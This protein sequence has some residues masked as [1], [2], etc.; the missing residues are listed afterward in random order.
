[1]SARRFVVGLC[2]VV[3]MWMVMSA[4]AFASAPETPGPV[5]VGSIT[6]HSAIL[7][8]VLNPN[9]AG[10]AGTYEFLYK[11]SASECQ[12]TSI[13]RGLSFGLIGEEVSQE[14]QG[15]SPNTEYAVC[16]LARSLDGETSLSPVATFKTAL[17]PETPVTEKATAVTAGS[18]VLHGTLNPSNPGEAGSYSFL[19]ASSTSTCQGGDAS[20]TVSAV[21]LKQEAVSG[22]V[23]GLLPNTTYT[24]CVLASNTAGE[25]AQGPPVT[26]TTLT[27]APV[28]SEVSAQDVGA[29]E[30]TLTARIEPGGASTSYRVEYGPSLPYTSSTPEHSVYNTN[31]AGLQVRVSNLQPGVLYHYRFIA[32]N[33]LGTVESTDHT[34]TTTAVSS[35]S[36]SLPD[37][38]VYERVS[39]LAQYGA[40]VY[41][42]HF[43]AKNY[44]ATLTE[45]PFEASANGE[46]V[47][48]VGAPSVGGNEL[49][50]EFAGNEYLA[51]RASGGGWVQSNISPVEAPTGVYQAF[52]NN[53]TVGFLDA[54]E[55]LSA[56]APGFGANLTSEEL[57]YQGNYDVLYS[58]DLGSGE[59]V[60][61]FT[62]TPPFRS[63]STFETAGRFYH[64]GFGGSASGARRDRALQFAGASADSSHVLFT[65]NDALTGA[66]EGRPAAEGGAGSSFEKENN[67]YETVDG[68]LRLVNVL[69]DGTTR[70]NATFGAPLTGYNNAQE[71]I[72]VQFSR[73]I[74]SDGSHVFWTDLATGHIYV[75]E[76]G[77][78][79]AEVS[80]AGTY[81]TASSDGSVV[82]Y[83][84]GDL[85]EYEVENGHTTDLTPGV[86][87]ERVIGASEDGSY[88][89]YVTA[90]GEFKL[91]HDGV[92]TS[93]VASKAVRGEV[94][95]DGHSVVFGNERER[96]GHT[97]F[98]G[99]VNVYDAD[100]GT[101]YCASC[102]NGGTTGFLPINDSPSVY[103]A[104]WIA[105]DG[106]RVFFM[107]DAGLVPQDTNAN[108]D[109]Y[110]WERPGIGS[111]AAGGTEGCLYL[112]SSG[113]N[114]D[115][116]FFLDS[117]ESGDDV[118]IDTRAKLVGSDED[119]LFDVYDVRVG[120]YV[121]PVPLA[122]TGA[123]CQGLPG[124]PPIFATP[125]SV[126]FEG[127]GNFAASS[128]KS[129]PVSKAK[130]KKPSHKKNKKKSRSKK[131]GSKAK[132]SARKAG[133]RKHSGAKGVRS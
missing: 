51:T 58:T 29:L 67:L 131:K 61:F 7:Y 11:A 93:I 122:C 42:P 69:P 48:Y 10:E 16:L 130:K 84:N 120:G 14:V 129:A 23:T 64:A 12:G 73:V 38:R 46:R 108:N 102:S 76:N 121:P 33:P 98:E 47:V 70:A 116:S 4:S 81:Q 53:L 100:T 106:G 43:V 88:V 25:T 107:S 123:G 94:T 26:F 60:P 68:Q 39:S 57:Q 17:P 50:G 31:S 128:R 117:S 19:Y 105:A 28:L 37:G 56:L 3:A 125:S 35:A 77:V 6:A 96:E 1:M 126:T 24:F 87:V 18:A 15:L 113:T 30:A 115:Q 111:C 66:S 45:L 90:S 5:T 49:A 104:R 41:V 83:T 103:Q 82:F 78:A 2:A 20:S 72:G 71:A 74:L 22:A 44:I 54:D 86:A 97:I 59:Y 34:F 95:P 62:V 9:A 27:S 101:L 118:F 127:V 8:G 80:S 92:T 132:R 63:R 13:G 112:L 65:A 89:Y 40:E 75:R 114:K 133:A 109:V 99:R 110:E 21:G 91:W 85:Y 79:T 119:N 55:P 36:P 52:S 124:A 32:S